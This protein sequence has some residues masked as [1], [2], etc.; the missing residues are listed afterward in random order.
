[1]NYRGQC[2]PRPL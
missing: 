2:D 1:M